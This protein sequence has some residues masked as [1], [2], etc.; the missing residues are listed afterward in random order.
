MIAHLLGALVLLVALWLSRGYIIYQLEFI[1]N[2]LSGARQ[3][4]ASSIYGQGP[5]AP[6]DMEVL[7]GDLSVEGSLPSAL[8]GTYIR[9]GPSPHPSL[10]PTGDFHWF[11]GDGM[12]HAVRIRKGTAAYANHWVR[13]SRLKQE[14]RAKRRLFIRLGDLNGRGGLLLYLLSQLKERL[15]LKNSKDGTGPANTSVVFHNKQVL[16][17]VETDLPYVVRVHGDAHVETLERLKVG[18]KKLLGPWAAHPKK[19]PATGELVCF[20]W[21]ISKPHAHYFVLDKGGCLRSDVPIDIPEPVFMHDMAITQDYAVILD[22]PLVLNPKRM[23]KG[24]PAWRFESRRAARIG[25]LPRATE[26]GRDIR[27]FELPALFIFHTINAWQE[28]DAVALYACVY[29]SIDLADVS[30]SSAHVE[31]IRLD[32]SSGK[33]TRRVVSDISCEFPVV[34]AC[35]VGRS[36]RYAY[37]AEVVGAERGYS[38]LA[39]VDLGAATP[40]AAVAGRISHGPG[41]L[42]GEA[43]FLPRSQDVAALKGED[44]GYLVTYVT[45]GVGGA[46]ELRV[47]DAASMA[48]EPV[49]A[50]RLPQRVPLGFHGTHIGEAD[51]QSQF[52]FDIHFLP[53]L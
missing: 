36:C 41:W 11:D 46:S 38:G 25:L 23:A 31:E 30:G 3:R 9:N 17:L 2:T 19:D 27:W 32:T 35:L 39:K 29:D 37:M 47:Y 4:G 6:V 53:D 48:A 52:P 18:G 44:D 45:H 22:L 7:E 28:G 20:G 1:I 12:V 26:D 24:G 8:D 43:T 15:G 33:A 40:A 21:K 42:G 34:P 49:A 5:Y 16:A 14:L 13:T 51:F 50:V 10:P